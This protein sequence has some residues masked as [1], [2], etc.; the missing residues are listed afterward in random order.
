MLPFGAN[1]TGA[2]VFNYFARNADNIIVGKYLGPE[3][4]GYYSLAYNLMLRPLGY[5]TGNLA[6]VF[7][8]ALSNIQEN[9]E[10]VR[11]VYMKIILYISL[12]TFPME[13]GLYYVAKDF[14]LLLYTLK[15]APVIPILKIL[16]IVGAIQSVTSTVGT[17][18]M[19]QGRTDL[20]FKYTIIFSLITVSSFLIGI[21]W[22]L[23]GITVSYAIAESIVCL[24]ANIVANK[25]INLKMNLYFQQLIPASVSSI[26]MLIILYIISYISNGYGGII[27]FSFIGSVLIGIASY[28]IIIYMKYN[29]LLVNIKNEYKQAY[30]V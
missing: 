3:S 7:F 16:C 18:Y 9:K 5:I 19:S 17:I 29:Y 21:R 20:Q 27:Y 11:S 4:L 23:I 22:G 28:S 26:G 25:L 10:K 30:I 6:R 24:Y 2:N 14:I 12:I 13:F 1:L 15:W 8:P